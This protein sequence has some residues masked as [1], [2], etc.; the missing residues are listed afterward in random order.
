MLWGPICHDHGP[1]E[2]EGKGE[3]DFYS[4][5]L[6][7]M[8]SHLIYSNFFF[9]IGTDFWVFCL[10]GSWCVLQST[11][12][13]LVGPSFSLFVKPKPH[14]TSWPRPPSSLTHPLFLCLSYGDPLF[15]WLGHIIPLLKNFQQLPVGLERKLKLLSLANEP[16]LFWILA[17]LLS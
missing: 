8:F 15:K 11:F 16:C 3:W 5:L 2:N 10:S 4:L 1:P 9:Q 6:D 13:I 12:W 14:S 7:F 17:V